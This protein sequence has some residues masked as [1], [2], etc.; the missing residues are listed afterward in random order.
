MSGS[1]VFRIGSSHY[2]HRISDAKALKLAQDAG[3]RDALVVTFHSD[4]PLKNAR[5][6][7]PRF[8]GRGYT[9]NNYGRVVGQIYVIPVKHAL[10]SL[11]L[12]EGNHPCFRLPDGNV[13]GIDFQPGCPECPAR[14][15]VVEVPNV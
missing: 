13:I 5:P 14:V 8:E 1:N 3:G 10:G 7:W 11:V 2:V 12:E 15:K 9:T 4:L 6:E